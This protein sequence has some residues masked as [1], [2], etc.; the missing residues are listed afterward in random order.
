MPPK[1]NRLAREAI[2]V[3]CIVLAV[4]STT[5]IPPLPSSVS[6]Q[7]GSLKIMVSETPG[8]TDGLKA[9]PSIISPLDQDGIND[10]VDFVFTPSNDGYFSYSIE[11]DVKQVD[12]RCRYVSVAGNASKLLMLNAINTEYAV[13]HFEYKVY[14]RVSVDLGLTWTAP[15]ET[16]L[17]DYY[18]GLVHSGASYWNLDL[19]YN[20]SEASYILGA[21]C[22]PSNPYS[23]TRLRFFK[24]F[25]GI[26]WTMMLNTS[27]F[28]ATSSLTFDVALSANNSEIIAAVASD[29]ASDHYAYF[30]KVRNNGQV[31]NYT[32]LNHTNSFDVYGFTSPAIAM[33]PS[34]NI[35]CTWYS[36]GG[37][38]HAYVTC[39]SNDWGRT[40]SPTIVLDQSRGIPDDPSSTPGMV[41]H[42]SHAFQMA[43]D[44]SGQ[45][46]ALMVYNRTNIYSLASNDSGAHWTNRTLFRAYSVQADVYSLDYKNLGGGNKTIAFTSAIGG[47]KLD[48]FFYT[49]ASSYFLRPFVAFSSNESLTTA[50]APV[51]FSW[52]GR[53]RDGRFVRD[54]LYLARAWVQNSSH[55]PYPRPSETR[56]K[57][58]NLA[59]GIS[60]AVSNSY[61]SPV[62]SLGVKDSTDI[63]FLSSKD[64]IY[65][66]FV[67]NIMAGRP[68][69]RI[70]TSDSN[71]YHADIAMDS[72]TRLWCVFTSYQDG[73]RAIYIKNSDDFGLSWSLPQIIVPM[74]EN[75]AGDDCPTIVIRGKTMFVVFSRLLYDSYGSNPHMDLY[76]VKSTDLGITWQDPVK[77]TNAAW[78]ASEFYKNPDLIVTGN[79]TLFLAYYRIAYLPSIK[80]VEMMVSSD[81]GS[82][83]STPVVVLTEAGS[84]AWTGERPVGLAFDEAS[85][86]LYLMT[87]NLTQYGLYYNITAQLW[88]SLDWGSSWT[89]RS[90]IAA[91]HDWRY[92]RG[93]TIDILPNGTLQSLLLGINTTT[94]SL[95]LH[96]NDAGL[97]WTVSSIRMLD[98]T[99]QGDFFSPNDAVHQDIRSGRSQRGDVFYVYSRSPTGNQNRDVYVQAF[100]ATVQHFHGFIMANLNKTIT[101]NGLDAWGSN[102]NDGLYNIMVLVKD[103]GGNSAIDSVN[104]TI[105]NGL[106]VVRLAIP[107]LQNMKPSIA[108]VVALV[109]G[110]AL[111]DYTVDL[112]YQHN[113]AGYVRVPM[114]FNGTHF[115]GIIPAF[116]ESE[117][118]FYFIAI[119]QSG[120]SVVIDTIGD[121]P[122]FYTYVPAFPVFTIEYPWN[123][124]V[125]IFS[126]SIGILLGVIQAQG[127][128]SSV[129]R[130]QERFMHMLESYSKIEGNYV[131]SKKHFTKSLESARKERASMA[132]AK[133]LARGSLMYRTMTI[134]TL[135][136]IAGSLYATYALGD[137]GIALLGSALGLL[138]S[139]L[140]FMERVNI[141][142][143][144]SIYIDKRPMNFLALVHVA[145]IIVVLVV[146]MLAAPLVEWFN[147]Y[148]VK[149]SF[150]I[151]PISIP[152]LYLSLVTPVVTSVA[153]ILYTSY[154]DLKNVLKRLELARVSGESW[155]VIWQ[156]KEETVSKLASNVALKKFIFLVTVSFAVI[157]TTQIGRYAEQGMLVL[158][159]FVIG[160]LGV[161][162]IGTITATGKSTVKEA[163]KWWIIEK[164][165]PCPQC[166]AT[167]L[168]ESQHCTSCGATFAGTTTIIEKTIDCKQ[169]KELSP[170]GSVHCRGCGL[171]L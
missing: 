131:P 107:P 54:G 45:L 108:Q 40:W 103:S 145:L 148:V 82:T 44:T 129:K 2:I 70:T 169:C 94:R 29:H 74:S 28:G 22:A 144:D 5:C 162:L 38:V 123:I 6:E 171:K 68:E 95:K 91:G 140:A 26:N 89:A 59:P 43:F 88:R 32:L 55:I 73:V 159:P 96:S 117:V 16:N 135:A 53:D 8:F 104:C 72:N 42:D 84:D 75:F 156:Q 154:H 48:Q 141:D 120:N 15:V 116:P 17:S 39:A 65:D 109:N 142:A 67:D 152:R 56:F 24:S 121:S 93:I 126:L 83:F 160:W 64:G 151:G 69:R 157:S 61:F 23:I 18:L 71:D 19:A 33:S 62:A 170:E 106:P 63:T 100:T 34:D 50:A 31:L 115:V 36:L 165:K 139:A 90:S 132:E 13:N 164:T 41:G 133:G 27:F 14:A 77:L 78:L 167:N 153:L 134:G 119:D 127:K 37:S 125:V 30:L 128:R 47:N 12:T 118:S 143:S 102:S 158:L 138:L 124:I 99:F 3:S 150:T 10:A 81:G 110:T 137:G 49:C 79:G 105:D 166:K 25:D 51:S 147:Y 21:A 161:F 149:Q 111:I 9:S 85:E 122:L 114:A 11:E 130:I 58:D 60:I 136:C 35:V 52:D 1:W 163:L 98:D 101:W 92:L 7:M 168:F 97:S 155:K 76:L 57:V 66:V 87:E 4:V 46:D 112:Y 113:V 146:F 86:A 80:Q 20:A